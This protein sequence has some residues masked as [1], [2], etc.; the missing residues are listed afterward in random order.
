MN[1]ASSLN[2]AYL[3]DVKLK[4]AGVPISGVS[5]GDPKD[6]ST[7]NVHLLDTAT[8][9]HESLAAQLIAEVDISEPAVADVTAKDRLSDPFARAL[10]NFL[11]AHFK[12]GVDEVQAELMDGLKGTRRDV[13]AEPMPGVS[14][15]PER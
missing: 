15:L 10:V 7:W 9:E 3:L 8:K 14:V 5:I 13:P 12:I 6:R 4:E 1:E 11:A 2:A